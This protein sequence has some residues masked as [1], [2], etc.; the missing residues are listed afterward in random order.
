M[1]SLASEFLLDIFYHLRCGSGG[2]GQDRH[3]RQELPDIRNLKIGWAEVISP[4]RDAVG[5]VDGDE[6]DL[7]VAQ[8]RLEKFGG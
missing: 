2:E 5:L 6:T 7:H 1:A 8:L 4:L 3:S